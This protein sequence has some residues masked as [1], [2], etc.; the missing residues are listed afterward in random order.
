[1]KTHGDEFEAEAVIVC[2][3]ASP[4]RLEVPGEEDLIGRG[5]SFCATCDGFFFRDKD[6]TVV[7]GGDSAMEE[8]L[9]LTR[10]ANS[11]R[12]IHRRDE[13]RAGE[14]LK[15]RALN[16]EKISFIWDSVVEEILGDGKVEAVRISNVKT[17][18]SE[19][20]VTNGV[21][22]F[23]GHDPNTSIVEGQLNMDERGYLITDEH[24][25]TNVPGVFAAGEIQ[26]PIYR[27]VAT[28]VGQGCAAAIMTERWLEGHG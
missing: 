11:I 15:K 25:A 28:S 12:V 17:G 8:S 1:M 21:F 24:M 5:V 4:R 13:L 10:F 23:I 26:D 2:M 20:L 18:E 22:V 7:G 14:A 27:Q 3:G 9:F 6:V 16:H 19:E